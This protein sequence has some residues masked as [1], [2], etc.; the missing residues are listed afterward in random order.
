MYGIDEED[1]QLLSENQPPIVDE[2]EEE[3]RRAPDVSNPWTIAKMNAAMKPKKTKSTLQLVTP[4]KGPRDVIKQSNSSPQS[5]VPIATLRTQMPTPKTASQRPI[6]QASIDDELEGSIQRLPLV[7]SKQTTLDCR[8]Q[9]S[10]NEETRLNNA[11]QRPGDPHL[12]YP[13]S[14][15][16]SPCPGLQLH[17][18]QPRKDFAVNVPA[19]LSQPRPI[20]V[21]ELSS[22]SAQRP[23]RQLTKKTYASP[24]GASDEF[25]FGQPVRS[26]PAPKFPRAQRKKTK[27]ARA[28][29]QI[30]QLDSVPRRDILDAAGR[31]HDRVTTENNADIRHF[32]GTNRNMQHRYNSLEPDTQSS[33][34]SINPRTTKTG[35]RAH[36]KSLHGTPITDSVP[37]ISE[38]LRAYAEREAPYFEPEGGQ[39]RD[40]RP[41]SAPNHR[42]ETIESVG[43]FECGSSPTPGPSSRPVRR[44]TTEGLDRARLAQLPLA[45]T[46]QGYEVQDTILVLSFQVSQV[47]AHMRKLDMVRNSSD[48]GYPAGEDY[49]VFD[50]PMNEERLT[51]WTIAIANSLDKWYERMVGVDVEGDIVE[52]IAKV[53]KGMCQ[54]DEEM[55]MI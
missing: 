46:P 4:M 3:E 15:L 50:L 32:L 43:D 28:L 40:E 9:N 48:W 36:Y 10:K 41:S 22:T 19:G 47:Q 14:P 8:V 24:I 16:P 27:R 12:R 17:E 7:P 11:R 33:F 35:S 34:T 13:N 54:E 51:E 18:S 25:W 2:E 21:T 37:D 20:P 5:P 1:M 29:I 52:G 6:V 53:M 31:F 30:Q 44:R 26:P 42:S 55:L 45:R 39:A 38:Q 23:Q 49:N